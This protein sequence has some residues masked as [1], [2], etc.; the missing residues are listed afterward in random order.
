LEGFV[1]EGEVFVHSERWHAITDSPLA[2]DQ[3]IVV[4]GLDGLTLRVR[5]AQTPIKEQEDV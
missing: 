2:A 1:T 5:A 3:P 4:T